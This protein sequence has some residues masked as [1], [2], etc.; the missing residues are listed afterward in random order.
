M[1][2]FRCFK[3]ITGRLPPSLFDTRK[4]L[5]SYWFVHGDT[6]WIAPF[7]KISL[8]LSLTSLDSFWFKTGE[9]GDFPSQG[10]QEKESQIYEQYLG[11]SD[12]A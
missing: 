1:K 9:L 3:F 7:N 8:S 4:K 2:L 12:F 10:F 11:Y 5:L 6:G